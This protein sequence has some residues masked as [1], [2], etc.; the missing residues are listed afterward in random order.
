VS[1]D[2]GYDPACKHEYGQDHACSA[3]DF[4]IVLQGIGS[5][6]CTGLKCDEYEQYHA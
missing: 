5:T 4:L 2:D 3:A 1:A 6:G